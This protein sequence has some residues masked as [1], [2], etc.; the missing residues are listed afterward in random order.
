MTVRDIT[1]VGN[2]AD[3]ALW[4]EY[5]TMVR[6]MTMA[7]FVTHDVTEERVDALIESVLILMGLIE[8]MESGGWLVRPMTREVIDLTRACLEAEA[9]ALQRPM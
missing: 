6:Q 8:Q 4:Y 5:L 7:T 2:R 9:A 1:L 3:A